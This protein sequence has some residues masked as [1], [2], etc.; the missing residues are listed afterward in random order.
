MQYFYTETTESGQTKVLNEAV[1][2]VHAYAL[3]S[4]HSQVLRVFSRPFEFPMPF[5]FCDVLQLPAG[6][7]QPVHADI[8]SYS[9]CLEPN[10]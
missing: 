3:V 8:W 5:Q 1:L 4:G 9:D 6:V 7:Q 2:L 10:S